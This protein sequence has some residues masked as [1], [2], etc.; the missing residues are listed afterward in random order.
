MAGREEVSVVASVSMPVQGIA[1]DGHSSGAQHVE[2]HH[3]TGRLS[4]RQNTDRIES[5]LRASGIPSCKTCPQ[6]KTGRKD[7]LIFIHIYPC[8]LNALSK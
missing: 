3:W 2:Q 4:P 7:Q 6:R 5:F 8:H 1:D